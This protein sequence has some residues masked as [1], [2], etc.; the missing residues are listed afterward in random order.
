MD[1]AP[2]RQ[3]KRAGH[4]FILCF[5]RLIFA[6]WD[7]GEKDASN[8]LLS[9]VVIFIYMPERFND[10]GGRGYDDAVPGEVTK[11]ASSG[12]RTT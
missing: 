6:D 3:G 5:R 2:G 12:Y 10:W 7:G 9:G 11:A 4:I 1:K 8:S